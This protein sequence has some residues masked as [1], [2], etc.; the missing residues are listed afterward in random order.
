MDKENSLS[1]FDLFLKKK[2]WNSQ[3]KKDITYFLDIYLVKIDEG[4]QRKTMKA[5]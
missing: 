3:R 5:S 4:K 2:Q 1:C